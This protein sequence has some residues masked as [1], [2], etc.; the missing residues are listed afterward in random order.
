[1]LIYKQN[2]SGKYSLTKFLKYKPAY[3]LQFIYI[4]EFCKTALE[5][6]KGYRL[7][8]REVFITIALTDLNPENGWHIF[9]EGFYNILLKSF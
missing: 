7:N 4:G 2:K 9:I 6:N 8:Q 1:M 3:Q 5:F